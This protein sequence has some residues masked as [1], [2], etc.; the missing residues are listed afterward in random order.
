MKRRLLGLA[1][2]LPL[3]FLIP[4]VAPTCQ[5]GGV[6]GASGAGLGS[7]WLNNLAAL[8]LMLAVPAAI[9]GATLLFRRAKK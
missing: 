6:K 7:E 9:A 1:L 8:A 4:V 2:L 5:R 3:G